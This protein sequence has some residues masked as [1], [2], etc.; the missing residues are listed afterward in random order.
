MNFSEIA[1]LLTVLGV[2]ALAVLTRHVVDQ[3]GIM[4]GK[5]SVLGDVVDKLADANLHYQDY[6]AHVAE[7]AS[8]EERNRITRE[9]HDAVGL[10][11]TNT[12]GMMNAVIKSPLRSPDE[13][14]ELYA[15]IRDTSQTGLRTTRAILY[16]LR[17]IAE[18]R[19][20][21]IDVVLRL[22]RAFERSTGTSVV[23]EWGNLPVRL[24]ANR[25]QELVNVIQE[26]LVN[27]FR[28]GKAS[29]VEVHFMIRGLRLQ[30]LITDNGAGGPIDQHGIGH[31]GIMERLHKRGGEVEF[32]S[33]GTGYEVSAWIPLVEDEK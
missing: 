1:L 20:S 3:L 7:V 22:T 17:S 12:I 6:A 19:L 18:P 31:E 24:P 30:T 33:S 9:L 4:Q 23:I 16:E 21:V 13:Q 29:R 14:R 25:Y 32:R 8:T 27:S 5:L 15:W 11:F 26:S 10:A 2:L 28:H